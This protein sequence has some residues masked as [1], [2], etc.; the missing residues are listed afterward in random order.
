MT[1]Y[2]RWKSIT[3]LVAL[4]FGVIFAVPNLFTEDPAVQ[5]ARRSYEP[6]STVQQQAI[7]AIVRDAGVAHADSFISEGRL[8]LRFANVPDQLKARDAL[9]AEAAEQYIVA[10]TR[11]TRI[12][13]FMRQL[14]LKPMSLGL[15][16]RGGLY[17]LY[18]VDVEGAVAQLLERLEQEFRKSLRDERIPYVSVERSGQQLRV[19]LRNATDLTRARDSLLKANPDLTITPGGD[20]VTLVMEL[21]PEQI[22]ERQDY[23][24]Q[25]NITTLR[26]RVNE[27]G[28]SEPIVQRQGLDRINVQLPGV[29]N[30][31]EVKDILGKTATLEFRLVD[32]SNDPQE[33]LRLG[34]APLGTKLYRDRDANPVL[35]R[36]DV[37]VTGDQLTDAT[38]GVT[39]QEGPAVFVKLDGRGAAEMLK[40]TQSNLGRPMAVVFIEKV[41]RTVERDG[42]K[43]EVD[44]TEEKVI[45]VATIQGVFSSSFQITGLQLNEAKTLA[46][47]LRAGS[48][49]API[50]PIEERAI[51]PSLGQDNI[52][53]GIGALIVGSLLLFAAMAIYYKGMGLLADAILLFNVV[54]LAALLTLLQASLTLPGIAGIV[55]TVAMAVDANILIYERIREELRIGNSPLNSIGAGFDKAFSA[56]A[57]SNVTAL[58]AG[59]VLFVFGTGPIKG[60]A[61][62]LCLGIITTLF[63]AIIGSRALIHFVYGRRRRVERLSI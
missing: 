31:A 54:L 30:S 8:M 36:R 45:S 18:Q 4:I 25:Q 33:A 40:T 43:V 58:I 24:I 32:T 21:R 57:D 11:A 59:V 62:T 10:L 3:V 20:E 2:P 51:G 37:I 49:A 60:F 53:K 34:R 35:L 48:L 38:S 5:V 56:I 61:V 46:L 7:E 28:V 23:A 13:K 22:K 55:L 12:P 39:Q 41:R 42:K 15:D 16:L 27:L 1:E 17:L 19:A 14:G 6:I 63:T 50:Y 9:A 29:Q 26:N 52:D 47:L 44:V